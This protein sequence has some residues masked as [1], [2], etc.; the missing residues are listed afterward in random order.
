METS[1][2]IV[3]GGLTG[4]ALAERLQAAGTP[5]LLAEARPRLGGRILSEAPTPGGPRVDLGPAWFWPGQPRIAALLRRLG[6][7]A[8]AQHAEG[9]MALQE[10]DGAVR[11]DLALS[12]MGGALRI[13]GG[14]AGLIEGIAAGLPA[15]RLRLGA[16]LTALRLAQNGVAADF[17]DGTTIRAERAALALPPR[18]AA[19]IA[20][21]PAP[22]ERFLRALARVPTWMAGQ[23]KF[24]ALYPAPF[25]R[26][27]GLSGD[28]VSRR[29]PLVEIHDA[30]PE[31]GARGALFG[32]IGLSPETRAAQGP[33]LA[34]AALAQL[35]AIFG[36]EAARPSAT[37]LQDWAAEPETAAPLDRT[38]P[39]LH[40]AYGPPPPTPAPWGGRLLIFSSE[41]S[42]VSGGLLEGAL[43]AAEAAAEALLGRP[44]ARRA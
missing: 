35:E 28:A 30:S 12:M 1:V 11:R 4:L 21:A 29:G 32:F 14:A 26:P 37:R 10:S 41:A 22:P 20:Y 34:A 39:L 27:A 24:V 3:G 19:G 33:A 31:D 7:S 25:W 9:R 13:A 8:F 38:G 18:L 44:A 40:P 23:A 5:W 6:L 15:E 43:E 17:A 42:A 2:L 36:P 16:R